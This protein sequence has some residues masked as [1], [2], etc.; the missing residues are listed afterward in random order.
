MLEAF[1]ADLDVPAETLHDRVPL[2]FGGSSQV[3]AIEAAYLDSKLEL[4][5]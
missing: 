4:Q 2:I 3:E 1:D 5:H